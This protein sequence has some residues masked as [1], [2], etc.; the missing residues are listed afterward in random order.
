MKLSRQLSLG[1]IFVFCGRFCAVAFAAQPPAPVA[2]SPK[3]VSP[4]A[5]LLIAFSG[6]EVKGVV[7]RSDDPAAA[8]AVN[9]PVLKEYGFQRL[10]RG[11]YIRD[12]GRNLVIKAAVFEDASGAYGAFPYYYSAE[13]GEETIGWPGAFLNKRLLLQLWQPLTYA[14]FDRMS[15]MSSAHL[16]ALP[17]LLPAAVG[18]QDNSAPP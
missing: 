3:P 16:R 7:D 13:M 9:A 12:D 15:V 2:V 1:L 8:D 14:M 18:K 17:S 4:P 6:W 5:V 10:E 11:A